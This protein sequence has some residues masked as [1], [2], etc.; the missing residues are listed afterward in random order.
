M[1]E[2]LVSEYVD[3]FVLVL[4][5][6]LQS[7]SLEILCFSYHIDYAILY[8]HT[9]IRGVSKAVCRLLLKSSMLECLIDFIFVTFRFIRMGEEFTFANCVCG[10]KAN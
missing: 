7:C 4:V 2:N 10:D 1:S 6:L 5:S 9:Q 3:G 8:L